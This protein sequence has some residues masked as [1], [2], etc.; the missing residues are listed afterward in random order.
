MDFLSSFY[1]WLLPLSTLPLIIHLFFNRKYRTIEYSSIEFLKVLKVD[2]MKKIRIVEILL[3]ILR[4]LIIIFI[5]LM[6]SKPTIQGSFAKTISPS[7]PIFCLIAIDDS[8]SMTR[9]N[10]TVKILDFYSQDLG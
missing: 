2:S 6:L 1:L 10:N 9:S 7:N 5:I 3:L 8:F 4:T